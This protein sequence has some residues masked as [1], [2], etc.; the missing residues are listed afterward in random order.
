MLDLN[1]DVE[2]SQ[3]QMEEDSG[4]SNSSVLNF[5]ESRDENS[6]AFVFDILKRE[7]DCRVEDDEEKKTPQITTK[8]LFPVNS[9]DKGR[10]DCDFRLGLSC[11][12]SNQWLNLSFAESGA[13]T[14]DELRVLQQKQPQIRKSRRGPRSRSSQYRG[15]TFYR[16]TGRWE[17]H[18]WDCGKQV[19]LGGFDTAH[20]AARAYDR[21]AIKF[22]GVDADIN[23]S[24]SDYE[25]DMKMMKGLSKE[26]F[27]Q[28]LRRQCSGIPRGSSKYRV[29]SLNKWGQWE[30]QASP[31]LGKK[32]YDKL[33]FKSDGR[34]SV[35]SFEPSKGERTIE[36]S[37]GGNQQNL[38]LSLGISPPSN[39][40]KKND[41]GGNLSFCYTACELPN[42]GGLMADTSGAAIIGGQAIYGVAM[43]SKHGQKWC[44]GLYPGHVQDYEDKAIEKRT[45]VVPLSRFPNLAWQLNSNGSIT[46]VPVFSNAASS[47]FISSSNNGVSAPPAINPRNNSIYNLCFSSTT[48]STINSSPS[49]Q[50]LST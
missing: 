26:E 29:L 47:K 44:S 37:R 49:C 32:I 43:P 21:A 24:L 1:V 5:E 23:F 48:T 39:E 6:S 2:G 38:D 36:S 20:T 7:S 3:P 11:P 42:K 18:I 22:R 8:P 17:S 34:G 10:R 25:E 14:Q 33:P 41:P 46:P 16:R 15:V 40:S 19:Y 28:V 31:F 13:G 50:S 12:R 45:E 9:D 30:A 4:T 35:T 27:V